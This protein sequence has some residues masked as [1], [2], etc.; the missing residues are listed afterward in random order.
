MVELEDL[1]KAG[2]NGFGHIGQGLFVEN[3]QPSLGVSNI[4]I[5][6]INE[7]RGTNYVIETAQELGLNVEKVDQNSLL[8]NGREVR[9][10]DYRKPENIEWRDLGVEFIHES[11]GR[12]RSVEDLSHHLVDNILLSVSQKEETDEVK[13]FPHIVY[14]AND[15][16]IDILKNSIN[17]GSTCT[18]N[19]SFIIQILGDYGVIEWNPISLTSIHALTESRVGLSSLNNVEMTKTGAGEAIPRVY[20]PSRKEPNAIAYTVPV[21]NGSISEFYFFEISYHSH[22]LEEINSI[23]KMASGDP[24]YRDAHEYV[25]N[26]RRREKEKDE[27]KGE[28]LEQAVDD[29]LKQN[30]ERYKQRIGI[31]EKEY[32]SLEDVRGRDFACMIAVEHTLYSEINVAPDTGGTEPADDD[33]VFFLK[34]VCYYDNEMNYIANN[35]LIAEE[36]GRQILEQRKLE[37]GGLK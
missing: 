28:E 36:I 10:T 6:W 29:S 30:Q 23:L 32:P 35:T 21:S 34:V 37:E 33:C 2:I 11:S 4:S 7:P 27:F 8:I 31:I 1:V 15:S 3:I 22:D 9:V 5:I 20:I 19:S 17:S 26:K 13:V 18:T 12:F 24:K 25:I 14:G 16:L